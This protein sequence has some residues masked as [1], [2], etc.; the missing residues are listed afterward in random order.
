MGNFPLA[1]NQLALNPLAP[2][3]LA[4]S[5]RFAGKVHHV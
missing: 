5:E 2:D 4:M 3:S 1:P